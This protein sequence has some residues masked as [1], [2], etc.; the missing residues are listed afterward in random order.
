MSEKIRLI[1]ELARQFY[2]DMHSAAGE[3]FLSSLMNSAINED[4]KFRKWWLVK[5]GY[6][7]RFK[8]DTYYST[9][10]S[11]M[12]SCIKGSKR[13]K[14]CKIYSR[15]DIIIQDRKEDEAWGELEKYKI[16]KKD[17]M[18]NLHGI[19]IEVKWTYISDGDYTK[20]LNF[21][22]RIGSG[23]EKWKYLKF[24]IVT[25]LS[26]KRV[27]TI[28]KG[29]HDLPGYLRHFRD[30]SKKQIPIVSFEEIYKELGKIKSSRPISLFLHQYLQLHIDIGKENYWKWV[31]DWYKKFDPY[32]Q[33]EDLRFELVDCI[34]EIALQSGYLPQTSRIKADAKGKN[35]LIFKDNSVQYTK[36]DE[37]S[38]L[39]IDV[40]DKNDKK[41][42]VE[43]INIQYAPARKG[44]NGN[45]IAE[46]L[47]EPISEIK[48][49]F[50]KI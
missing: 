19:F 6:D 46:M 44:F 36:I 16:Q 43:I 13:P 37:D 27:Q 9:A 35:H 26:E 47:A 22:D 23:K 33:I 20:Y 32:A 21:I 34:L 2:R 31:N 4:E 24:L 3:N 8:A 50:S 30:L 5:A 12:P 14:D 17:L 40:Y 7:K 38:L 28:C 41:H 15:P 49:I 1:E 10:N 29:N 45:R 42:T 18:Q 39:R 25:M 11:T 48:E